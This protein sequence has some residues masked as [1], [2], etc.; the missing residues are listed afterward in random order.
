MAEVAKAPKPKAALKEQ[1]P[2]QPPPRKT[3]S[4]GPQ[5]TKS[6]QSMRDRL[7]KSKDITDAIFASTHEA[8][9]KAPSKLLPTDVKP[10]Q[11]TF[12]PKEQPETLEKLLALESAFYQPNRW[13]SKYVRKLTTSLSIKDAKRRLRDEGFTDD[14]LQQQSQYNGSCQCQASYNS[15]RPSV[16]AIINGDDEAGIVRLRNGSVIRT[17]ARPTT[18]YFGNDGVRTSTQ[19]NG[20]AGNGYDYASA[21]QS[22][23]QSPSECTLRGRRESTCFNNN[24]RKMS[25]I[26]AHQFSTIKTIYNDD[27]KSYEGIVQPHKP[28]LIQVD[29]EISGDVSGKFLCSIL[30]FFS[31]LSL[32][33]VHYNE[34]SI[35]STLNLLLF[36]N[37]IIRKDNRKSFRIVLIFYSFQVC[38]FFHF[39]LI[40]SFFFLCLTLTSIVRFHTFTYTIS[41][42]L[43]NTLR[44]ILYGKKER[45]ERLP[46]YSMNRILFIIL[47][48]S[49]TVLLHS[50]FKTF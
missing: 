40:I 23:Y 35:V 50:P 36:N 1:A 43:T 15:S 8:I 18:M 12:D 26:A 28:M 49:S 44:N 24:D 46:K 34:Y 48:R 32:L 39:L 20:Y 3:H 33:K 7:K 47:S 13:Q 45:L 4:H 6:I 22:V 25:I 9:I 31:H 30:S 2:A 17:R 19:Q 38:S 29:F 14:V 16:A 42:M 11:S 10:Q 41:N 21:R 37:L 5:Y 27:R